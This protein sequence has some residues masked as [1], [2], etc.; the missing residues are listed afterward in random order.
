M[1]ELCNKHETD[2]KLMVD[3]LHLKSDDAFNKIKRTAHD[4]VNQPLQAIPTN[5]QVGIIKTRLIG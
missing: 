1:A 3:R 5:Q 2:M 4:H